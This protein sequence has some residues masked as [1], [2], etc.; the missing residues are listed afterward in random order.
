M[1]DP[2]PRTASPSSYS[3]RKGKTM[4]SERAR[5]GAL[6]TLTQSATA[7]GYTL[8]T[9]VVDA[10]AVWQ[11][12]RQVELPT[13]RQ[14]HIEDAAGRIVH[15][16]TRGEALDLLEVGAEFDRVERERRAYDQALTVLRL[17]V[18]QAGNAAVNA[19]SDAADRIVTEHLRPAHTALLQRVRE[20]VELL[21][22]HIDAAYHLDAH[23]V[24]TASAKVRAAYLEVPALV[25]RWR[26]INDARNRANLIG[27]RTVEYDHD[28]VFATFEN[29]MAL[30]PGWTPTV[31][32]PRIPFPEGATARL[33]WIASEEVAPARPWLPTF[34]EQDAAYWSIF[35]E[36]ITQARQNQHNMRAMAE[37]AVGIERHD[38]GE[39][40]LTAPPTTAQRREAFAGRLF[41]TTS[42]VEV[43]G[44]AVTE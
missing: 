15:T 18:E 20:V 22:P 11:R 6:S 19:A 9:D 36:Q 39:P 24:M 12:L 35:G 1:T 27:L 3:N 30:V 44:G 42:G 25:D 26:L 17:A 34:A 10:H 2:A 23:G 41:G 21:R 32:M 43:N 31:G 38:G 37:M 4:T 40:Q 29:P 33:L 5:I 28:G 8:P 7:G 14:L 16:V 13:P